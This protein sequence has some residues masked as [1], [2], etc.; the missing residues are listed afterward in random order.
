MKTTDMTVLELP[1]AIYKN[2]QGQWRLLTS[3][4][5]VDTRNLHNDMATQN[6][7]F[8]AVFFRV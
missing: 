3:L 4:Q 8:T 1:K 5:G 6:N 7:N 2:K